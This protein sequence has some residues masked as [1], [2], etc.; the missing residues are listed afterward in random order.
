MVIS[1]SL[2]A[3]GS[4]H[5]VTLLYVLMFYITQLPLAYLLGIHYSWGAQG[6]FIAILASELIL[7]AACITVFKRGNWKK[8]KI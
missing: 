8:V 7:A 5:V 1:R 3:A 6:I 2:N 4:V